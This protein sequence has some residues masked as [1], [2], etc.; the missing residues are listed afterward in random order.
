MRETWIQSLGWDD[1]LEGRH[2]NPLQYSC[3][4]NPHGQRIRGATV[5]GVPG[6]RH[7]WATKHSTAQPPHQPVISLKKENTTSYLEFHFSWVAD[8][9]HRVS[10]QWLEFLCSKSPIQLRCNHLTNPACIRHWAFSK[11]LNALGDLPP[12]TKGQ[13]ERKVRDPFPCH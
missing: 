3:L 9:P 11:G 6:V 4:E 13:R 7:D 10:P 8:T 5:H 2:G 12:V 1:S